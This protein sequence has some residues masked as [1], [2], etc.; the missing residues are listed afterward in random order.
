MPGEINKCP[1]CGSA[2]VLIQ[3]ESV[4]RAFGV[5]CQNGDDCGARI[6]GFAKSADAIAAWNRRASAAEAVATG[7]QHPLNAIALLD[8]IAEWR[9]NKYNHEWIVLQIIDRLGAVLA[10]QQ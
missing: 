1:F 2:A 7:A 9:R 10:Q 6:F 8:D 5:Q 3:S 4:V